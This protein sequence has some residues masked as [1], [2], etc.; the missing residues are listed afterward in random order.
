MPATRVALASLAAA[1]AADTSA[2]LCYRGPLSPGAV[3][4]HPAHDEPLN[5]VRTAFSDEFRAGRAFAAGLM[6]DSILPRADAGGEEAIL[7][8]GDI[9][10]LRRLERDVKSA[11]F[12]DRSAHLAVDA[13]FAACVILPVVEHLRRQAEV[14]ELFPELMAA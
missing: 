5:Y 6:V 1:I 4:G 14:A 7:V 13:D 2:I 3:V 9:E 11:I 8:P 12:A 10:T